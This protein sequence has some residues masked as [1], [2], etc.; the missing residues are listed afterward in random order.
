MAMTVWR[1]TRSTGRPMPRS[2]TNDSVATSSDSLTVGAPSIRPVSHLG[3]GDGRR[4]GTSGGCPIRPERFPAYNGS[5]NITPSST[6]AF[7]VG[8]AVLEAVAA[9]RFDELAA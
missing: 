1:S 6:P 7:A 8:G 4:A 9:Q 2:E 5:V 3:P